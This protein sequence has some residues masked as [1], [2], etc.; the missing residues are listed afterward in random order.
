MDHTLIIFDFDGTLADTFSWF[1]ITIDEAA[2][3]FRFKQL[4]KNKLDAPRGQGA[5]HILQHLDIPF[6]K[7]PFVVRH[8]RALM[9]RDISSITLFPGIKNALHE[10][11][12][13]G[14]TLAIVTT[15]SRNNVINV[16]GPETAQ[17]F[18]YIISTR[19]LQTHWIYC[20]SN[21]PKSIEAEK[22]PESMTSSRTPLT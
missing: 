10:L 14:A 2:R 7:L 8:M 5:R 1:V 3:Q 22:Y 9:T 4:D 15:N 18:Q 20:S 13:H 6:W 12:N 19:R 11:A 21:V 17:L 16:L